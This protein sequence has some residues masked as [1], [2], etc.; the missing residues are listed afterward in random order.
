GQ[1]AGLH[2]AAPVGAVAGE[3]H[4]V[5]LDSGRLLGRRAGIAHRVF[6]LVD[7]DVLNALGRTEVEPQRDRRGLVA[8]PVGEVVAVGGGRGGVP[9]GRGT[10]AHRVRRRRD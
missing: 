5:A 6:A 9:A 8:V 3:V 4:L 1:R 7:A 10:R 2:R